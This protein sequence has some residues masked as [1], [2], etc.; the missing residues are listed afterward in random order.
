MNV[1]RLSKLASWLENGAPGVAFNIFAF[2]HTISYVLGSEGDPL[3]AQMI[4]R[5][6]A[7]KGLSPS[8]ICCGLDGA[9]VQLFSPDYKVYETQDYGQLQEL[10]LNLLGLPRMNTGPS[11]DCAHDLFDP[12]NAPPDCSPEQAAKAVRRLIAGEHPWLC[13]Q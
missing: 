12:T 8:D 6:V 11:F 13:P 3:D 9:T 4:K 5:Q 2:R 10:A 7:E 1:E